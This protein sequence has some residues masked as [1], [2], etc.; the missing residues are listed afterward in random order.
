MGVVVVWFLFFRLPFGHVV[1]NGLSVCSALPEGAWLRWWSAVCS[2]RGR[3]VVG[4]HNFPF[5]YP[6]VESRIAHV[7]SAR[8]FSIPSCAPSVRP[9]LRLLFVPA[10]LIGNYM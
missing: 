4:K 9:F 8:L 7:R 10:V 5:P 2:A 3:A 1:L 6:V